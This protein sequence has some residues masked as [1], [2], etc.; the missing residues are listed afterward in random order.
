MKSDKAL[1][2]KNFKAGS[3]GWRVSE[4]GLKSED[5]SFGKILILVSE[6]FNFNFGKILIFQMVK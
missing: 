4:Q 2:K 1:W 3:G 6:D 5:F